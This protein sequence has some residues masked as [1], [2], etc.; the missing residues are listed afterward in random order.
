MHI[1]IDQDIWLPS[2]K[3]PKTWYYY[4]KEHFYLKY[5]FVELQYGTFWNDTSTITSTGSS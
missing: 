1:F 4:L 5:C 3:V 2:L